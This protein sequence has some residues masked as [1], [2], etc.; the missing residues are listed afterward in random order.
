MEIIMPKRPKILITNDDG[1]HA[2]GIRV[3][4]ECLKDIGDCAVIAPLHQK[5]GSG[6]SYT[7]HHP[8]RSRKV[9][10][11]EGTPAWSV[12]GTPAD[13]VKMAL[14]ALWEE[15]PDI[16]VSGINPGSNAGRTLLYSGTVGCV[17]EATLRGVQGIAFSTADFPMS[18]FQACRP[19]IPMIIESVLNNPLPAGTLL[20]VN[21]PVSSFGPYKGVKLAK[22]GKQFYSDKPSSRND[23]FGDTYHWLESISV[24][25]EE[26]QESDIH[27]M[28]EGYVAAAPIHIHEMTDNRYFQEH[29]SRFNEQVSNMRAWEDSRT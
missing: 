25:F 1:I 15:K 12:D 18:D 23:P 28:N 22:Q 5:S 19:F 4:W 17:I 3:L 13:S 21:F 26:D 24:D 2:P 7:M 9:N 27:Y 14:G 8:I 29:K 20:N 16:V 11:P 10:W 6:V